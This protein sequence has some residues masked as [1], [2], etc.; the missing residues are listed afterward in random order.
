MPEIT[1]HQHPECG[2]PRYTLAT[3]RRVGILEKGTPCGALP[4]AGP[5]WSDDEPLGFM[6]APPIL[7]NRPI[8]ATLLGIECQ[9]PEEV[10]EILPSPAPM[11]FTKE[12]GD[13]VADTGVR[14]V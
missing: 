14:H 5:K 10:P 9:P 2:T 11:R 6:R 13:V 3:I 12:D 7:I 4:L 1:I 8:A